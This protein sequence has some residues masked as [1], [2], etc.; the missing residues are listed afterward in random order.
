MY[1]VCQLDG[2]LCRGLK[3]F[4]SLWCHVIMS[5]IY[6]SMCWV[7][8]CSVTQ[9][10]PTLCDPMDCSP[11]SSSVRGD[12]PGKDT[13]V[14]CNFLLQGSSQPRDQTHICIS[15]IDRWVLYH[16]ATREALYIL[17]NVE[18]K[19]PILQNYIFTM[20]DYNTQEINKNLCL[21]R[22]QFFF[23]SSFCIF[24]SYVV[25]ILIL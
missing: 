4:W 24:A 8:A 5:I 16:W 19:K 18:W 10:C 21:I 12:S 15:C 25:M 20:G 13:A 23:F 22:K 2:T 11:P 3:C 17:H 6:L 14:G 1:P 7:P 9:P